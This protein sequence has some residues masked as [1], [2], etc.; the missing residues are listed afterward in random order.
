MLAQ[1]SRLTHSV[2]RTSLPLF[3]ACRRQKET[4]RWYGGMSMKSGEKKLASFFGEKLRQRARAMLI[5]FVISTWWCDRGIKQQGNTKQEHIESEKWPKR[6]ERESERARKNK[7][8]RAYK[9]KIIF[10]FRR[11]LFR[12][13][14]NSPK[15]FLPLAFC[16]SS[17][18]N[19]L[20]IWQWN[21][22]FSVYI[23][24][25]TPLLTLFA[26]W[27]YSVTKGKSSL[28]PSR[29]LNDASS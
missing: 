4:W 23:F 2:L 7:Q 6:K 28:F 25:Y 15:S 17:A 27:L 13:A 22:L 11:E 12:R 3:S 24:V 14:F 19:E 29:Q 26:S 20:C 8:A 1:Y 18:K 9:R 10:H 5:N 16:E 21:C